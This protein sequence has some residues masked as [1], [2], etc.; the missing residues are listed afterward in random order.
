MK[1]NNSESNGFSGCFT[2]PVTTFYIHLGLIRQ[3]SELS[4]NLLLASYFFRAT[5]L[6][7]DR[8]ELNM[9]NVGLSCL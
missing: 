9:I 6:R 3:F 8:I 5:V 2:C 4:C 1:I 7:H